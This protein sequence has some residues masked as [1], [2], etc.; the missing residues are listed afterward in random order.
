MPFSDRSE[1]AGGS[2]E[3]NA[4]ITREVLSGEKGA[5]R[6]AV[7]LNSAAAIHIGRPEI[8]FA[9]GIGI[10]EE[11]IDSGKALAQLERFVEMSNE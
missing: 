9:D 5:R 4:V 3:E 7:L 6:N 11:V 2:P 1:L 10:V 8:S